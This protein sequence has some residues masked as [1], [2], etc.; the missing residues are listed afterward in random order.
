MYQ[1]KS[2]ILIGNVARVKLKV[3]WNL[4]VKLNKLSSDTPK[5]YLSTV[6][7]VLLLCY[8]TPTD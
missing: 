1:S 4:K 2:I 6:N 5:K 3:G 8:N 7:E